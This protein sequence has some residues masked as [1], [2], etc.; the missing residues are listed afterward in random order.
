L[1][2]ATETPSDPGPEYTGANDD[3]LV[4]DW[5]CWRQRVYSSRCE[6]V[7]GK[8]SCPSPDSA[9]PTRFRESPAELDKTHSSIQSSVLYKGNRIAPR[10]PQEV[11]NENMLHKFSNAVL[12]G[13][14]GLALTCGSALAQAN[15]DQQK[16]K[17]GSAER[18]AG[19]NTTVTGCLQQGTQA[20]EY[21]ISGEDG[22]SYTLKSTSVKLGDHL[23]HKV[24][25]TGKAGTAGDL[26]VSSLKMVSQS[27][28]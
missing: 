16:D 5:R 15:P 28:Q 27:C 3:G 24:S 23:N 11:R 10:W 26:T 17:S 13:V 9:C 12:T 1:S 22:K 6:K 2:G 8:Q 4:C 18:A 19:G 25:V 14:I 20:D 7:Q 21:R